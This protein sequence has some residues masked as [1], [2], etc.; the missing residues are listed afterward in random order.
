MFYNNNNEK[1][2]KELELINQKLIFD[3]IDLNKY[4]IFQ[5][6]VVIMLSYII[7]TIY[8]SSSFAKL[9]DTF[10]STKKD[11][12][13][14]NKSNNPKIPKISNRSTT[15]KY[16]KQL[17]GFIFFNL[18][19]SR[20]QFTIEANIF[21][22]YISY[23][24]QTLRIGTIK[25][26]SEN[27]EEVNVGETITRIQDTVYDLE[28]FGKEMFNKIIPFLFKF[29]IINCY[30]IYKNKD[31]GIA[32][33]CIDTIRLYLIFSFMEP[34][35][36]STYNKFTEYYRSNNQFSVTFENIFHIQ[37]NSM[38][39]EEIENQKQQTESV[40]NAVRKQII[41]KR[42]LLGYV[43]IINLIAFAFKFIYIFKKFKEKKITR[44]F[45]I[46]FVFLEYQ[47]LYD[48]K[49][50]TY[51]LLNVFNTYEGIRNGADDIYKL[52]V[53]YDNV[54][55]LNVNITNGEIILNNVEY[56]FDGLNKKCVFQD[57]NYT[58]QSGQ[59]YI[60]SGSSGSGKS[61]LI[62]L[63]LKLIPVTSGELTISG[64]LIETIPT[65]Q[66]R[67]IITM[68][69]QRNSLFTNM[70]MQDNI[71]YGTNSTKDDLLIL[72][73]KYPAMK[74]VLFSSTSEEE[75]LSRVYNGTN[76]SGG[77]KR[78]MINLR[79]VLRSQYYESFIV[80]MDEPLVGLSTNATIETLEMITTEFYNQTLILIDHELQK[81]SD[82]LGILNDSD[83][84][85]TIV[86]MDTIQTK[87]IVDK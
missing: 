10:G 11:S 59:N 17:I 73:N 83:K 48:Y 58:F 40:R 13:N 79:G 47:Y 24:N 4:L 45:M 87:T 16:L 2:D 46:T 70:T 14:K 82:Y 7:S 33:L 30:Y 84:Q 1:Q 63:L 80:I 66:L 85:F 56:C 21:P 42:N 86:E 78:I 77:Q 20:I 37:I 76:A 71:L 53:E 26:R 35:R 25:S 67:I 62:S 28:S 52:L 3:Y 22:N 75:F 60:L 8:L 51:V 64:F 44:D 15:S 65:S 34:Y 31:F 18:I 12:K 49:D 29:L 23:V 27:F 41:E 50:F 5:Y 9:I 32:S 69:P 54:N 19:L 6:F 68:I 72:L 55:K 61:S 39:D 74:E 57:A 36:K 81:N 38:V 43:S